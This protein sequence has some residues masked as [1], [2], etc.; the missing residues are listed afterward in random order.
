ML[1]LSSR[2]LPF[3]LA[4]LALSRPSAARAEQVTFAYD[5]SALDGTVLT[6][7]TGGVTLA[8]TANPTASVVLNGPTQSFKL[9]DIST[10]SAATGSATFSVDYHL[11]MHLTDADSTKDGSVTF[12]GSISGTLTQNSST[13]QSTFVSPLTQTLDLGKHEYTITISP[14]LLSL[15]IPGASPATLNAVVGVKPLVSDAP[16]PSTLALGLAAASLLG[17]AVRARRRRASS[18]A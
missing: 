15:P 3:L 14:T 2:L 1:R 8:L 11:K 18:A 10:T 6:S 17:L 4:A 16:E 9:A 13:L 12:S 7:G 5:T